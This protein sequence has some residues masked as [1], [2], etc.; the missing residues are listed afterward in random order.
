[1][2]ETKPTLLDN[3]RAALE[4]YITALQSDSK[5]SRKH[6][7]VK[8]NEEIFENPVNR[9]CDLTVVFPEVY[10]YIL[11]S[12]SDA[13]EACRE[14]AALIISNFIE[15][16]PLN[17]YYL[18]YILPVIVRR[19]GCAETVEESEEIRLVLIQ[20]VHNILEKYKVTYLLSP[21][22]GDF[23]NILTKT[24]TDPFP[25]VKLEA[26]ECIILVTKILQRDFHFQCES[27]VKPI[28]SNFG[29]QHFRVRVAAIKAIGN[30]S[31]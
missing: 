28:L 17:D 22:I 31:K 10:A 15:K 12:F 9:D 6:A 19:I 30:I 13:S 1:M 21:F 16:L 5:M 20:L 7:L 11:K 25:K 14:I 29:H 3:P 4:I 27:Y 8:L 2:S 18:T 23:T 26:C 24:V